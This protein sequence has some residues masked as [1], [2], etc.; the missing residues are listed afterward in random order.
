[1]GKLPSSIDVDDGVIN[2]YPGPV[3]DIS[4]ISASGSYV[5]A[6][7]IVTGHVVPKEICIDEINISG[8]R[9]RQIKALVHNSKT[10]IFI[11]ARD[12]EP[13]FSA[14]SVEV[15]I[16][17]TSVLLSVMTNPFDFDIVTLQLIFLI[18][19][20]RVMVRV[21]VLDTV[22]NAFFQ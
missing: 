1:M 3:Y 2:G 19:S 7:E 14:H 4:E 22:L 13:V 17:H 20:V 6:V 18:G 21:E 5:K 15:Q 12:I 11:V 16:Y 8:I 10:L 9:P